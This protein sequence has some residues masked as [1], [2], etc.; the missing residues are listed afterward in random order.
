M[1]DENKLLKRLKSRQKGAIDDAVRIYTPY[2]STVIYNA[3]RSALPK[4]DVEEIISDT[5]VTLWKN[6]ER[7]D[8][9]QESL[10]PY[11]AKIARNYAL[12]RLKE[13]QNYEKKCESVSESSAI[14][15]EP[16]GQG[17]IW[18]TVLTLG[19]TDSEIFVRFYKYGESLIHISRVTGIKLSTVKSKLMRGKKKLK[20]IINEEDAI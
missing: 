18:E 17:S 11:I 14:C 9:E 16:F 20:K 2:L 4:E 5:F 6:A 10:R 19:E 3:V 12:K 13:T 1:I 15:G 7:L 8:T